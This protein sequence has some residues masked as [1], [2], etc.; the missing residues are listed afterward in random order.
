M[1]LIFIKPMNHV[2]LEQLHHKLM[3]TRFLSMVKMSFT[4]PR[5]GLNNHVYEILIL[6]NTIH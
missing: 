2:S 4:D 5:G 1:K 6:V 3:I